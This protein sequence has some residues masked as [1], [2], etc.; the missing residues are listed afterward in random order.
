VHFRNLRVWPLPDNETT[1][2]PLPEVDDSFRK[3]IQLGAKNYPLVDWHVHLKPGLGVKEAIAR[4]QRD[5]IYYGIAAN[6][7]RQSQYNTEAGAISFIESVKGNAAFVGMQ[8]EGA[9]WMKIFTP[10]VTNR[11]D[12]IFNDGMIWTDDTGRWTR[13]YRP[14]DIGPISNPEAFMDELVERSVHLL[15]HTPM[16]ILAI[17]TFLPD[18]I[19]KDHARLWTVG[20]MRRLVDAA[21]ARNV[22]IEMNDRYRLPSRAF[23]QMAKEAGCKFALGTG[24]STSNDLRRNEFGLEMIEQLKLAWS[25]LWMPSRR[26]V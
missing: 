24:N 7:G 26:A 18:S 13:L 2:G 1:P 5:G 4:S 10:R 25:D 12:F 20:R 14:Q 11:F 8:A 23:L 9:D 22:A 6:C 16:D 19:A 21:A 3:I 17:P 15:M